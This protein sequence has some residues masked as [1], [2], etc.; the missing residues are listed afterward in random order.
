MCGA[1]KWKESKGMVSLLLF[2]ID[3]KILACS[4]L[5]SGNFAHCEVCVSTARDVA[6]E[7][8]G[9]V[10]SASLYIKNRIS[11]YSLLKL[12]FIDELCWELKSEFNIFSTWYS[13]SNTLFR[14]FVASTKR[15]PQSVHR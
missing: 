3:C 8:R 7:C 4:Y 2:T 12:C 1:A 14:R 9:F 6:I 5:F 11:N 10:S 15:R 13:T